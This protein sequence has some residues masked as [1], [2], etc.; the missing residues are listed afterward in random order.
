MAT[1]APSNRHNWGWVLRWVAIT[2]NNKTQLGFN[3]TKTIE[4]RDL[5]VGLADGGTPWPDFREAWEVQRV[6]DALECSATD[7]RWVPIAEV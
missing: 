7:G 1:I 6:V 2:V 5:I 4:V 3:D